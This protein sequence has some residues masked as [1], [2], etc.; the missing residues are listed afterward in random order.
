MTKEMAEKILFL[1]PTGELGG[2]EI[3]LLGLARRLDRKRFEPHVLTLSPGPFL[4]DLKAAGVPAETLPTSERFLRL[5]WRGRRRSPAQAAIG[6]VAGLPAVTRLARYIRQRHVALLHTN[7][8]KAHLV[9]WLAGRMSRTPVI[10]HVRDFLGVG[11]QERVLLRIARS[12]PARIITNSH[13]VAEDLERRGVSKEIL[14]PIHNGV[15]LEEFSPAVDGALFRRECGFDDTTPLAGLVAMLAPWKG[16]LEFIEAAAAIAREFP[17]A[18]FPIVGEE[19]Y[20]TEGHGGFRSRL[21]DHIARVGAEGSVV[22]VGRR[23]NMPQVMAGL[24]IVVHASSRPEPFG[25]VLIEAMASGKPVVATSAGGVPEIVRDGETGLLVPPGE[26]A[27]LAAAMR[28]LLTDSH[29]RDRLGK[30][31]RTAAESRFD[32]R[33]HVERVHELYLSVL[34][35]R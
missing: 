34:R 28:R 35:E 31:G 19:I 25:R 21:R 18:R 26:P 7:G 33:T 24:D 30:A 15:D 1:N 6:V 4:E 29:L 2:A 32:L 17:Q 10:W 12:G 5:S 13:A 20:V 14:C 27:S 3:S 8:V 11:R 22:L 9:G 16:H 23:R